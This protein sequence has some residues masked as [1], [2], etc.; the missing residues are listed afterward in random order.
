MY[1]FY[2]E[3]HEELEDITLHFIQTTTDA[4]PFIIFMPFM[5]KIYVINPMR[6]YVSQAYSFTVTSALN[7]LS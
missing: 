7:Y 6:H 2:H 3:E 5:V 4:L 1:I